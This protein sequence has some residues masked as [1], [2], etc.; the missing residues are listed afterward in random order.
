MMVI[1]NIKVNGKRTS[2]RIEEHLWDAFQDVC[3]RER[4]GADQVATMIWE[5]KTHSTTLVGA[6]RVFIMA[7]YRL[8][9]GDT[10]GMGIPH[11]A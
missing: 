2:V 10:G 1:K 3:A 11:A 8:A 6:I 7:Y 4:M 9:S 5:N